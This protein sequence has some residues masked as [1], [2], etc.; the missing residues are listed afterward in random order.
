MVPS[1]GMAMATKAM[2][3][4]K[5][6]R[7]VPA[8][9]GPPVR[10]RI[11]EAAFAAFAERGVA[12]TSSLEMATPSWASRREIFADFVRKPDLIPDCIRAR[13]LRLMPALDR[14]DTV[15]RAAP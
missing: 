15:D 2:V 4:K 9:D 10:A 7:P 1:Q 14:P 3:T 13:T 8:P 12:D 5:S 11:L 6:A